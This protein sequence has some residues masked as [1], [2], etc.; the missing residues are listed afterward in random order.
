MPSRATPQP[1][2]RV[3]VVRFRR[4]WLRF[5]TA[6]SGLAVA[7]PR[8]LRPQCAT[9]DEATWCTHARTSYGA[10]TMSLPVQVPFPRARHHDSPAASSP[11][12]AGID[13]QNTFPCEYFG[14]TRSH[15]L[16]VTA[17]HGFHRKIPTSDFDPRLALGHSSAQPGR[18]GGVGG[19]RWRRTLAL[20]AAL[21]AALLQRAVQLHEHAWS[22]GRLRRALPCARDSEAVARPY[23][24]R[25]L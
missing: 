25:R 15:V 12:V 4:S 14:R 7:L 11:R 1:H 22:A 5:H 8:A 24:I 20:P 21:H 3:H 6:L 9:R 17:R 16:A 23:R 10:A 2:V 18:P 13:A 19:P